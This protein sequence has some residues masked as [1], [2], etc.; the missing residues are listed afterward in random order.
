MT[1]QWN[2]LEPLLNT[3]FTLLR[4][5]RFFRRAFVPHLSKPLLSLQWVKTKG[6]TSWEEFAA[7]FPSELKVFRRFTRLPVCKKACLPLISF[8]VTRRRSAKMSSKTLSFTCRLF[9]LSVSVS[10]HCMCIH[11][12]RVFIDLFFWH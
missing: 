10:L 7:V 3:L 1:Q 11:M 8:W 12:P 6:S 4:S 5:S 2:H 9:D